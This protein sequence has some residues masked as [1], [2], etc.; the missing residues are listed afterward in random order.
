M[1]QSVVEHIYR[2]G[3]QFSLKTLENFYLFNCTTDSR[4]NQVVFSRLA[5]DVES[6]IWWNK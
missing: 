6:L 3:V 5:Q 4:I 2:K 1:A